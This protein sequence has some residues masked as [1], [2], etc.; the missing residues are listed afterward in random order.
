VLCSKPCHATKTA[1]RDVPEIA[2]TRRLVEKRANI[3]TKRGA[4]MQGSRNSKFKRK[5][6]GTVV[7]R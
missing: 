3:R 1:K 7:E 2:R 4:P 5:M 6:D